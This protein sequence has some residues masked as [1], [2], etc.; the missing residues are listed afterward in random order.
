[1]QRKKRQHGITSN[2]PH[3]CAACKHKIKAGEPHQFNACNRERFHLACA[4]TE[5]QTITRA[6]SSFV[7][8][9]NRHVAGVA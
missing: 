5:D 9:V 4:D 6:P 7:Q 8:H 3:Y 1:M 2:V